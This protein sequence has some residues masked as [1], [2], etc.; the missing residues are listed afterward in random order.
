MLLSFLEWVKWPIDKSLWVTDKLLLGPSKEICELRRSA[1]ECLTLY[2][3]LSKDASPEQRRIAGEEFRR[4]GAGLLSRHVT[5]G[6]LVRWWYESRKGW[7]IHSAGE[8]LISIGN[9]TEFGGFSF[10]AASPLTM[11]IRECL[12]FPAPEPSPIMRELMAHVSQPAPI[13]V[14]GP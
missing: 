10:A 6:R 7:D 2:G 1:L 9:G 3:A 8:M 12:R 4:I 11:L 13:T 14:L 5:A